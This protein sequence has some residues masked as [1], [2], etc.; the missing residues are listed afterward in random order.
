MNAL[1]TLVRDLGYASRTLR[2]SSGFT[3][4]AITVLAL[5]IGAISAMFFVLNKVLLE[6]LPYPEPDRL[7]QL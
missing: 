2:R 3:V 4:T 1:R 5:G 7:V 6:P